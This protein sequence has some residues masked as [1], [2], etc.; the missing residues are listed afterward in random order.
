MNTGT[1]TYFRGLK[2]RSMHII[3]M[4]GGTPETIQRFTEFPISVTRGE[5]A[6]NWRLDN[7]E[8]IVRKG[9]G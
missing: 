4:A 7:G 5:G 1:K 3:P 2:K 8:L 9:L 6:N